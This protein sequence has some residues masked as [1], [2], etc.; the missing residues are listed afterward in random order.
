MNEISG[1][2]LYIK[3]TLNY[4]VLWGLYNQPIVEVPTNHPVEGN[5]TEFTWQ[6]C[7]NVTFSPR[8]GIKFGHNV[9]ECLIQSYITWPGCNP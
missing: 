1:Y 2:L 5:V 8:L 7:E 3:K 6:F 9:G 4:P